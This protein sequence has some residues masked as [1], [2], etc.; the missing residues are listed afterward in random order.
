MGDAVGA[1]LSNRKHSVSSAQVND[2]V[3]IGMLGFGHGRI[4][5][6]LAF[7]W[8][9]GCC[10]SSV[11]TSKS[12]TLLLCATCILCVYVSGLPCM[13]HIPPVFDFGKRLICLVCESVSG[14]NL[15][16]L[17]QTK[18]YFFAAP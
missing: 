7:L 18:D 15:L 8:G 12:R 10:L 17:L 1:A 9:F 11:L 14:S 6:I 16:L 2:V 3:C 4:N 13:T 5:T